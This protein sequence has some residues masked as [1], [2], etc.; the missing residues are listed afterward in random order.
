MQGEETR[1]REELGSPQSLILE[2]INK[3]LNFDPEKISQTIARSLCEPTDS[4][5]KRTPALKNDPFKA[6]GEVKL[7]GISETEIKDPIEGLVIGAAKLQT[8]KHELNLSPKQKDVFEG[9]LENIHGAVAWAGQNKMVRK[10]LIGAEVVGLTLSSAGCVNAITTPEATSPMPTPVVEIATSTPTENVST[11][12]PT[13]FPTDVPSGA[14]VTE[15]Q[16]AVTERGEVTVEDVKN[17]EPSKKIAIDS[18]GV[19]TGFPEGTSQEKLDAVANYYQAIQKKFPTSNVYYAEDPPS[20][21]WL[22][23]ATLGGN[24]FYETYS[25]GDGGEQYFDYPVSY[26]QTE[27]GLSVMGNYELVEIPGEIGVIWENG[28]PQFLTKR[29]KTVNGDTYFTEYLAYTSYVADGKPWREIAGISSLE[30]DKPSDVWQVSPDG[31]IAYNEAELYGGLFTIN[32]EH[33]EYL[34]KY[35]EDTVRGL[36]NINSVAKNTAFV[37]KFPTADSLVD[38]LQNGGGP[39]DNLWIPVIY[40]DARRQYNGNAT[41]EPTG[42]SVDLS[43]IAISIYKPTIEEIHKFSQNYA[44]GNRYITYQSYGEELFVQESNINGKNVL[45]FTFRKD[46]LKD[47]TS[48]TMEGVL[49]LA[50]SDEKNPEENLLA[51]TQLINSWNLRVR[52]ETTDRNHNESGVL[53]W[54]A[55]ENPPV[56][57]IA[58]MLPSPEDYESITSLENTPLTVR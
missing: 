2:A 31:H 43:Q 26:N 8:A 1:D 24:L 3:D 15:T 36:W 37:N 7:T 20:G 40:P 16:S 34:E 32:K 49:T 55:A 42:G 13:T 4:L 53:I 38:Y 9:V 21:Q 11:E 33:P 56:L 44:S 54:N 48:A 45:Q 25:Y 50:F 18:N 30:I 29:I 46:M 57:N 35:W 51:A 14:N 23:Y 10:A 27:N 41:L 17:V 19:L 47:V 22:L 58:P 12:T 52:M 6:M 39:V 28:L 5:Y